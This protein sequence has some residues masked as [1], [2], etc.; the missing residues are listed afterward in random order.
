MIATKGEKNKVCRILQMHDI[1]QDT[2]TCMLE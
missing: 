2:I 1:T